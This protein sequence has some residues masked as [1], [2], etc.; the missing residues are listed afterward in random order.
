VSAAVSITHPDETLRIRDEWLRLVEISRRCPPAPLRLC[1]EDGTHH[2]SEVKK[3]AL[4]GRQYIH[5]VNYPSRPTRS[6]LIGTVVHFLVLGSR[7]GAKPLLRYDGD[8]RRGKA[9]ESFEEEH[10]NAE[11]VTAGEWTEAEE[12]AEAVLSDPIAQARLAGARF[13]VPVRWEEEGSIVCSTSGIDIVCGMSIADLKTTFTTHPDTWMKHA[14]RMLYPMQMAWYRRGARAN[15]IDTSQGLFILG[16]ETKPPF[17]VVELELTEPMIDFAD[18]TVSLWLEKLRVYRES[19]QFP[20]YA[21]SPVPFDVPAW[22]RDD[23]NEED[24]DAEG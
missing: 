12:I 4:S 11:I 24:D 3:L 14:F 15:G 13:E 9:W 19:N 18:R 2:F 8:S 5:G 21:Q 1:N 22:L 16:V 17:E 6:S 23:E 20:G 7:P 10:P